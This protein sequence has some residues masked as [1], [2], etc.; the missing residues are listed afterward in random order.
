MNKTKG[1]EEKKE[2]AIA[3]RKQLNEQLRQDKINAFKRQY[4]PTSK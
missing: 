2:R 4:A 3:Y 1:N